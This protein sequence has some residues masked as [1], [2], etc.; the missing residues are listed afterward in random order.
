MYRKSKSKCQS[1]LS[2][3]QQYDAEFY[4]AQLAADYD[5][6]TSKSNQE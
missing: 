1:N 5:W 2:S 3:N 6:F 4:D